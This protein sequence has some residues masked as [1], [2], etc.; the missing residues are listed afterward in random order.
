MQIFTMHMTGKTPDK[1]DFTIKSSAECTSS[2]FQKMSFHLTDRHIETSEP[3]RSLVNK[4]TS[5]SCLVFKN[6]TGDQ[7][8]GLV[9]EGA[10][11]NNFLCYIVKII[12]AQCSFFRSHAAQNKRRPSV[13]SFP[14]EGLSSSHRARYCRYLFLYYL[15]HARDGHAW[16]NNVQFNLRS[17]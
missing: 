15:T 12:V 7:R 2:N 5:T 10:H 6:N 4:I 11:L 8:S 16:L 17:I 14:S 13:K 9:Y 1:S 3:S